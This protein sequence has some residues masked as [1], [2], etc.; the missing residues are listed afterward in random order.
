MAKL[1]PQVKEKP[2][3]KRFGYFQL[4]QQ[5]DQVPFK[6]P[7]KEVGGVNLALL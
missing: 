7:A 1:C 6:L 2:L 3:K 5:E 4:S